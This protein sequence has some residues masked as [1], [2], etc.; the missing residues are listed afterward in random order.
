VF[1]DIDIFVDRLPPG[2]KA[3][4]VALWEANG[5]NRHAASMRSSLDPALLE[6]GEY[7]LIL[8]TGGE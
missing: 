7:A 4:V 5:M 8:R 3:V 6:K 2:D 1:H